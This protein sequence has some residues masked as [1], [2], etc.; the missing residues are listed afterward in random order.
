MSP[1]VAQSILGHS[2]VSKTLN[3][4]TQVIPESQRAAM[5]RVAAILDANGRNLGETT[6][7]GGDLVN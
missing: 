3:V 1:R 7:K 5:E 2:D 6:P 4:Y